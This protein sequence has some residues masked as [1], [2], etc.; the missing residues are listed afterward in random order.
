MRRLSHEDVDV[1]QA[2]LHVRR[3]RGGLDLLLLFLL[4]I[5]VARR[6]LAVRQQ[7]R[8]EQRARRRLALPA[9]RGQPEAAARVLPPQPRLEQPLAHRQRVLQPAQGG[10][11]SDQKTGAA[12]SRQAAMAGQV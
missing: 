2:I 11:A 9:P 5:A 8:A 3:V 7:R 10:A 4:Q 1:L 12:A 6:P